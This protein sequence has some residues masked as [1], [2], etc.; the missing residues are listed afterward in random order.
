M[1]YER[2]MTRQA[3]IGITAKHG[4]DEWIQANTDEYIGVIRGYGLTPVVLSPDAATTLPD[5]TVY[6]PDDLGRLPVG[7]LARLDGLVLAGGG[8]VDPAYFGAEL[9]GANEAG[10]DL[11]RDELELTLARCAMDVDL[12]TLGVCRGCQVLNVAAGGGMV[13][14]F[15]GHRSSDEV[16]V[17]HDI[18]VRPDSRFCRQVGAE[19]FQVNTYHHQGM[20]RAS[21]SPALDIVAMADAP[22]DW[23]VEAFESPHHRWI[24]GVQWHPE[25][26][27]ELGN[28]HRRLW[29]AFVAAAQGQATAD[30]KP[31]IANG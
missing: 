8:D 7:L 24:V 29:D 1:E 9:D 18:V 30:E 17:Y 23:L 15:D 19:R 22:D 21:M 13:Q 25:R 3:I 20:D 5:G 10:I 28:E 4:R 16:R 26:L 12:P 2:Q 27:H 14:H 31:T 11:K 6:M